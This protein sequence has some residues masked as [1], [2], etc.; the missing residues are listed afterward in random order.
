MYTR[1]RARTYAEL[2]DF[3]WFIS[4]YRSRQISMGGTILSGFYLYSN[5]GW[6]IQ[7]MCDSRS[8]NIVIRKLNVKSYRTI[9]KCFVL[10]EVSPTVWCHSPSGG[11]IRF[12]G[13]SRY[14]NKTA[15]YSDQI[16]PTTDCCPSF[17]YKLLN[18]TC[19]TYHNW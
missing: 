6:L 19:T 8:A 4:K 2:A 16:A 7:S 18:G 10:P 1:A 15:R 5:A 17:S 11:A 9:S 12:S 3:M 13:T 14:S